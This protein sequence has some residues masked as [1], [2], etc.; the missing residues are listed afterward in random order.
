MGAL[1]SFTLPGI[2]RVEGRAP[3]L[4]EYALA[5]AYL[6]GRLGYQA[7]NSVHVAAIE[8]TLRRRHWADATKGASHG[9][10][11]GD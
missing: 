1:N 2:G 11:D 5:I 8:S 9:D 10:Q 6:R 4:D 7:D 3:T